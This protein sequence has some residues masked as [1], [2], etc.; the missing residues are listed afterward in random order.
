MYT[1]TILIKETKEEDLKN[2]L[3][4]WNNGEVMKYVGFPNG[5]EYNYEKILNWYK[6]NKEF[7]FFDHYSIYTEEYGYC[8]ETGYEI[9]NN[10]KKNI[11]LDIK[12][13]SEVQGRGIAEYSLRYIIEY[14]CREEKIISVWVDPNENN[15]KARKLYKKIG[16]IEKIFPKYLLEEDDGKHIYMELIL[17][18]YRRSS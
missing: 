4:L 8:G 7:K 1:G 12:L 13:R 17:N 6:K 14:L 18:E 2:I 11:G 15:W 3:A 5:L 16:F 9:D 10:G